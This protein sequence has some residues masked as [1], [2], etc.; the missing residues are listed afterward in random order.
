MVYLKY[1]LI[2]LVLVGCGKTTG[3]PPVF[4]CPVPVNQV[5]PDGTYNLYVPGEK[6]DLI[7]QIISYSLN[8]PSQN[9]ICSVQ[10]ASYA[11]TYLSKVKLALAAQNPDKS[12][13]DWANGYLDLVIADAESRVK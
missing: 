3:I 6:P 13:L 5:N 10:S 8:D 1:I 12:Y 7:P 9:Y 2:L 4:S 11:V